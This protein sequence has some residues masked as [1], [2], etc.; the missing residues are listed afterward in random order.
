MVEADGFAFTS[1]LLK[2]WLWAIDLGGGGFASRQP[3]TGF[4]CEQRI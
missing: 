2:L 3:A 1:D 4:R